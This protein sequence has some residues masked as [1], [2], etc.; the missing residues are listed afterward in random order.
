MSYINPL[1]IGASLSLFL[2]F[3]NIEFRNRLVNKA[4]ASCFAVFLLHINPFLLDPVYIYCVRR[5]Y[6]A[7]NGLLCMLF[8]LA[9][10]LSVALLALAIDQVRLLIWERFVRKFIPDRKP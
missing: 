1:T 9:F 10:I 8:I 2:L 5:I 3:K 6:N 4:A 7:H